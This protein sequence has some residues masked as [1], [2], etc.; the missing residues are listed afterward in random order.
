MNMSMK[1]N[2]SFSSSRIALLA[3]GIS[4]LTACSS[5]GGKMGDDRV[6]STGSDFYFQ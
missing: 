5:Q 1:K 4:A 2:R 6:H 3:L